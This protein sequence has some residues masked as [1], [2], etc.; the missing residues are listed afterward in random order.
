DTIYPSW[1]PAVTVDQTTGVVALAWYD[2]RDAMDGTSYRLY[3]AQSSDG[4]ATFSKQIAVADQFST[5]MISCGGTGDGIQLVAANG[6]AQPFWTD[7]RNGTNQIFGASVDEAAVPRDTRL[8]AATSNYAAGPGPN[9]LAAKDF[10]GD[11]KPDILV[12][13]LS[14]S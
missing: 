8:F 3:Y 13:N 4:G 6:S 1:Q 14:N 12:G 2:R 9:Q 5:P 10:N 11:G 7:T